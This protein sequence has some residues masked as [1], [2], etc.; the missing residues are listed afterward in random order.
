[1]NDFKYIELVLRKKGE[2]WGEKHIDETENEFRARVKSPS[3][4]D[5]YARKTIDQAKG[6]SVVL[7]IRNGKSTAQAYRFDKRK[8]KWSKSSVVAWLRKNVP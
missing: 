7:G 5:K 6:I 1:M 4:F 3:L 8:Y 2:Q